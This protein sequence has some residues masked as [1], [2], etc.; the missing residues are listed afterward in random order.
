MEFSLDSKSHGSAIDFDSGSFD[1][2]NSCDEGADDDDSFNN[3]EDDGGFC[4]FSDDD[5][6]G[7]YY[8]F[9]TGKTYTKSEHRHSIRAY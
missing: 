9:N 8:D 4:G 6:E 2:E 1:D 5:D 3:N 7:Y